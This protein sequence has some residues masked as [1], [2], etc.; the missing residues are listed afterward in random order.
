LIKETKESMVNEFDDIRPYYDNEIN[1]AMLRIVSNPYFEY[2]INFLYPSVPVEIVKAKFRTFNS[3]LSFQ[4]NVMNSAI[5][6]IVKNSSSGF[7]YNGFENLDNSKRYVFL[8]NHRDILLDS[9]LLQLLLHINGHDTSEITFGDNLMTSQL[10]IDIGKSNKMFR[11]VRGGTPKNIFMNSAHT[12]QY[13]RYAISG[14]RQSVWIAQRNG[15]TKDGNDR[16]QQAVLKMLGMSGGRD[17]VQNFSQLSIAPVAISYEYDP[18]DF[19]KTKEIF[20]SRRQTYIKSTGED[21]NSILTGI[22][23]NKGRIHLA[24][25]RPVT[26][27][28]LREIA[29]V[30]KNERI[31]KLA[32]LIDSRIHRSFRIWN[33]NYIASDIL[34]GN[35][36]S[37]IYSSGEKDAFVAYMNKAIS[38]IEGDRQ[39]LESIFLS[40][41]ANPVENFIKA[42]GLN[43]QPEIKDLKQ[44]ESS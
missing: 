15:R 3:V 35:R 9:A 43:I 2:I 4:V 38:N 27:L 21:L 8:S 18:G 26:E 25:T 13:I 40:I 17:F 22:K 24:V 30:P 6:N 28:E 29:E 41:Y 32:A 16:T 37:N 5:Q 20:I 12:S 39:E 23:Q 33:T 19:L 1:D 42:T 10:I 34:F 11:L 36:F 44:F 7:T 14:K 31:E